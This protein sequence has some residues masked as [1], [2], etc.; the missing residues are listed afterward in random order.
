MSK[1]APPSDPRFLRLL[2]SPKKR[3]EAPEEDTLFSR[4]EKPEPCAEEAQGESLLL[5]AEA[6]EDILKWIQAKT[7]QPD[8]RPAVNLFNLINLGNNPESETA[9]RLTLTVLKGTSFEDKREI[10]LEVVQNIRLGEH[11]GEIELVQ[12]PY[13]DS[14]DPSRSDPWAMKAVAKGY[15]EEQ[16]LGYI[17]KAQGV[18]QSFCQAKNAGLL[19][20][21]YIISAKQTMFKGEENQIIT[22]VAG[23][24]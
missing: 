17:P 7:P 12:S 15:S 9:K 18:N 11:S 1:P 3:K 22:I 4:A 10:C 21:C 14:R 16:F 8:F 13:E 24:V 6:Q 20:G 2:K 23:W 19:C 5:L